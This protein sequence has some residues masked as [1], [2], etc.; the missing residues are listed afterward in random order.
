MASNYDMHGARVYTA[1]DV[2]LVTEGR[3]DDPEASVVE[4]VD[5]V[6]AH[7]ERV[8]KGGKVIAARLVTNHSDKI[9]SVVLAYQPGQESEEPDA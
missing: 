2:R 9:V 1:D 8:K 4:I 3:L 7:F 6:V 5:M